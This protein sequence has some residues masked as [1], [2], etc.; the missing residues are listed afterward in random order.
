MKPK[1]REGQRPSAL[2]RVR[3]GWFRLIRL[4]R[5]RALRCQTTST[6][7]T[8]RRRDSRCEPTL[9]WWTVALGRVVGRRRGCAGARSWPAAGSRLIGGSTAGKPLRSRNSGPLAAG[10]WPGC[11]LI[12]AGRVERDLV[13]AAD[14]VEQVVEDPVAAA[15]HRLV[16]QLVDDA[17]ARREVVLVRASPG[18]GPRAS[19][20]WRT[21]G[22]RVR[23]GSKLVCRFFASS[24]GVMK[25]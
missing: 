23:R 20:P 25:S 15:Q 2:P 4:A 10:R 22:C 14:A 17:D 13:L 11:M 12:E 1:L 24:A 8:R 16:V 7:S 9:N 6:D 5:L 21:P 3:R 19:R 18:R